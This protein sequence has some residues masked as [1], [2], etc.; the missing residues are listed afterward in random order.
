MN[1]HVPAHT[2]TAIHAIAAERGCSKTEVVVAL[3]N[4]GLAAFEERRGE[5][6]RRR[7]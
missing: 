6:V 7:G 5:F 2:L 4:E 1:V 3:L